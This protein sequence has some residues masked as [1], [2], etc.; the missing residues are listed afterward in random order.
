MQMKKRASKKAA[1]K[2][3]ATRSVAP[4]KKIEP[5]PAGYNTVTAYLSIRGAA[6][7]IDF[8]KRAFGAREKLRMAAPGGKV[9]HAEI[10]IGDS[11][12]ML[13]DEYP[14]I[15]FLGPQSRG[16]TSVTLHLYVKDCDA[17]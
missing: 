11:L 6:A 7:A 2:K 16:G 8:Y 10:R 17:V 12:V 4:A 5:I 9:G 13:A 14:D 1:A 15:N 3:A